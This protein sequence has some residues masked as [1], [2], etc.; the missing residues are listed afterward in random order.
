MARTRPKKPAKK[1]AAKKAV[2][3]SN[4]KVA[5]TL[6]AQADNERKKQQADYAK[7]NKTKLEPRTGPMATSGRGTDPEQIAQR[8]IGTAA[9]KAAND[10][11]KKLAV[12]VQG[13]ALGTPNP[14][15][16]TPQPGDASKPTGLLA[17]LTTGIGSMQDDVKG[18]SA[19]KPKYEAANP[20]L[21]GHSTA[22]SAANLADRITAVNATIQQQ[23]NKGNAVY[24][25]MDPNAP[26][27]NI[28]RTGPERMDEN[29][30]TTEQQKAQELI[31]T[32]DQLLGWLADD[33]KV[34][35]I[36]AA[37]EKAGFTVG[38]YDDVS[39]LWTAVVS[40]AASAYSINSQK[41]TPW[42]LISL[43]GKYLVNGRPADRVTTSTSIDEMT[44]EE[45]RL[46]AEDSATKL[47]GRA[48]TKQEL[49]DFIAKA[50]TI[51][52]ANPAVTK[53]THHYDITGNEESQTNQT[54][55]GANAVNA[56]SQV[57]LEDQLKQSEDYAAFQAAGNYFPML[58][59]ALRSP[60]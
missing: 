24:M 21:Y 4:S 5:D 50:Q 52:K 36:K 35:Q 33:T 11:A 48:P 49:D 17:G 44:P 16:A 53:T 14:Y 19:S 13:R 32:K 55:G 2:V 58:F 39:K 26:T 10:T 51:S 25:G 56:K 7:K 3:N 20:S 40:Q 28:R 8:D 60:V 31:L 6:A 41:V 37:A 34:A 30:G 45:A 43:R 59:D 29:G 54:T 18:Q 57:A 9:S 38:S 15:T 27:V 23:K 12:A 1:A 46:M 47:L 42:A 22:Q